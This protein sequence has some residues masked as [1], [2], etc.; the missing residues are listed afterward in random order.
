MA[1]SATVPLTLESSATVLVST[2]LTTGASLVPRMVMVISCSVPSMVC[3]VTTSVVD[4]PSPRNCTLG[5]FSVYV[6]FPSASMVSE[7]YVPVTVSA[8]KPDSPE[9]GSTASSLAEAVSVPSSCTVPVIGPVI[10]GA[11][12]VPVM[13]ME[14]LPV[15]VPP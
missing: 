10:T 3:T 4:S 7:P 11:P 13:V 9:S 8:W 6:Q 2:E 15:A 1:L 12:S 5:L 14:M